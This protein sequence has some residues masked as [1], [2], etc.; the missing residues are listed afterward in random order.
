[1]ADD[2]FQIE[3]GDAVRRHISR[4]P[5]PLGDS[6]KAVVPYESPGDDPIPVFVS[7]EVMK[8][9]ERHTLSN[10]EQEVGGVLLGG[11]FRNDKGS[12]VEVTDFIDAEKAEGTDVSLTFTHETWEQIHERVALRGTDLQIVGWYHSHPGLGVFMSKEDEFIHTSFFSDP[13]HIAIVHDPIYTNWGCF[14]WADGQLART[15]GFY[16]FAEKRQ[17]RKVRDYVKTQLSTR[18]APPRAASSSADRL[19]RPGATATAPLWIALLAMLLIQLAVGWLALS[20]RGVTPSADEYATAA[21][22]LR[23]SDLTGAEEQLRHE[24]SVRPDNA[25]AFK[26]LRTLSKALSGASVPNQQFDRQNLVLFAADHVATQQGE[27]GKPASG[28]SAKAED[29]AAQTSGKSI[30]VDYAGDDPLKPVLDE[31]ESAAATRSA[32]I[33]RAKAVDKVAKTQWSRDAV[34]W[35]EDEELRQIA[36]GKTVNPMAYSDRYR[37]LPAAKRKTVDAVLGSSK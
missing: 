12:F 25:A 20:R 36:Y 21:Q 9:I 18:Q 17:A 3:I 34:K 28:L 16:V 32:R 5:S 33:A 37:K 19:V 26:D 11:F 13:W 6:S 14:K 10:K 22:L 23:I 35:L 1:M 27:Q 30:S 7:Q 24:L 15:G 2:E 29:S 31:Y 8:A 4:R